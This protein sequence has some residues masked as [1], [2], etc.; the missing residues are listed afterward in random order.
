MTAARLPSSAMFGALAGVVLFF[1]VF[2][3]RLVDPGYWIWLM[4]GDPAT[5]YLGWRF[6]RAEPWH[7]PPGMIRSYGLEVGSAIVFTD[8]IPIAAFAAKLLSPFLPEPFQYFGLWALMCYALQGFFGGMLAALASERPVERY[9]ITL[10]FV[11]S[12]PVMDR[13]IGHFALMS[14]WLVLWGLWLA[15][16]PNRELS[17]G[18]WVAVTC[19]ASL[20]HAYLL[21][22]V[23]ALWVADVLRR[24]H[25]DPQPRPSLG[26]W[27]R[28][29]TI[30]AMALVATMALAGYFLLPTHAV[31]GGAQYYGKYAT[32]LN[33]FWNPGW[34]SRF[35]PGLAVM[36]GAEL[37]GHAYLGL[38]MLV[39]LPIALLTLIAP[40][41]ARPNVKPYVP[42]IAVGFLLWMLAVSHLVAWGDRVV[43]EIPIRGKLL[44]TIA[45]L[46][47]SG[48]LAWVALYGL[49]FAA[50]AIVA[51]RFTPRVATALIVGAVALQLADISPRY[52]A[53]R[54][55]F[56]D[57]FIATP[58]KR[59][60]PLVSPFWP[61]AAK[62]YRTIRMAPVANM[63]RGWEWLSLYAV[64]HGMAINTGQF[65]RLSFPRVDAA[66]GV[67]TRTL[68]DGP[69]DPSTLYLLWSR[70]T[71][72][73]WTI[74]PDDGIGV[75][76]GYVVVAPGWFAEPRGSIA[77]EYL[78]RGPKRGIAP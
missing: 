72:F 56:A 57:R 54:D 75:F 78:V 10:L 20:V 44:D 19:I 22:I 9:A 33:A 62:H 28:H 4:E 1:L 27:V 14:H 12:L 38:G 36:K 67:I 50:V 25:F 64:D 53:M 76:D 5:Q 58:A 7:W 73:D 48:R 69:L 37:E 8:S 40:G 16:R 74:G 24:R 47:A 43:L 42:L 65:A 52:V 63:A 3:P 35:L 17:T 59:A 31:T 49:W 18:Q 45:T 39:L 34:G 21:Y 46:R 30:V 66:N 61:E 77:P 41:S 2:D 32:N 68:K 55:Y 6:F 60:S 29:V 11:A 26:D 70:D 71:K 13:A 15:L 51:T 23:L